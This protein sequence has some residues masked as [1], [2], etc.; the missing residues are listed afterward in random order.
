MIVKRPLPD[1]GARAKSLRATHGFD[2][3]LAQGGAVDMLATPPAPILGFDADAEM[4]ALA[5][6]NAAR[7]GLGAAVTFAQAKED[8]KRPVR[9]HTETRVRLEASNTR[10][11]TSVMRPS[12]P[13]ARSTS[14][15]S[16]TG[17]PS[18]GLIFETAAAQGIAIRALTPD[19][20]AEIESIALSPEARSSIVATGRA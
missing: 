17:G 2:P 12:K 1:T 18:V 16:I 10:R 4:V 8:M 13:F 11:A 15:G 6:R 7:A 9:D 3:A 5:A 20:A 14:A 19:G